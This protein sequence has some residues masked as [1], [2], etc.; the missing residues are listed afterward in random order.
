MQWANLP[1]EKHKTACYGDQGPPPPAAPQGLMG[2]PMPGAGMGGGM[3]GMPP[4]GAPGMGGGP[5]GL[6]TAGMQQM[7]QQQQQQMSTIAPSVFIDPFYF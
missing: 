6:P 3:Q 2:S 7:Q 5:G 1:S 4:L